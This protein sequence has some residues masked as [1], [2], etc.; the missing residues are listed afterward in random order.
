MLKNQYQ[1]LLE[2]FKGKKPLIN[3]V[4][5]GY[6]LG[7]PD[8][9][10]AIHLANKPFLDYLFGKYPMT[11]LA[12]HG[13]HVGLPG[14]NDLGGSEVGHLT[15]GAGQVIFQGPTLI[16]N[17]IK[18]GSFF[19]SPVLR[20]LLDKAAGHA[21]HLIGLLSDGNVHSHIDHFEA[22]ILEAER[23]KIKRLYLHALLDG[24]D[25]GIQT[26]QD[27]I[28]RIQSLFE[29]VEKDN[30]GFEYRIASGGGREVI[31]MDRDQNWK[32]VQR[33]WETHVLGKSGQV[34]ENAIL[35]LEHFR[36]RTPG[37]IDQDCPPF[38]VKNK[39]GEIPVIRD[40][41]QVL[42]M[43]FRGDRA[44]QISR[45]FVEE[46]FLPFDIKTKPKVGFA[47]IMVYD[48]DTDLPPKRIISSP[49]V[50]NPFGKRLVELGLKQFRLAE[51]QKYAHVTF[52]Y[53]GGYRNP[54]DPE[55]ETY[56]LI[57]SDKIDS[58]AFQPKMKAE[59]IALQAQKAILSQKYDFGLINFAN[60][61]MV[62]HTGDLKATIRAVETVDH[63]VQA[64]CQATL[65]AGGIAVITADHGNADEMLILNPKTK[66]EEISTKH[67]ISPVPFIIYDPAH[68]D[69]YRLKES[70]PSNPLN[71]SMIAATNFILMGLKVP[72]DLNDPLFLL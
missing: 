27:Y 63:A 50:K 59:E 70:D 5:D 19:R 33:G 1:S 23:K 30:P 42:F 67:S 20:E 22:V 8:H 54:L 15:M 29:R 44:A 49:E 38:N 37:L 52:F 35:A 4:L 13:F 21:L 41:D 7:K 40:L 57:N 43:N 32:K 72:D 71:L 68:Q 58:F 26:A 11:E 62:G 48:E 56:Y 2:H 6:G 61:D 36:A 24:R 18:D 51:T 34:F 64:I 47:G 60:A 53:N 25:V 55:K 16:T 9:T 69:L 17:A 28:L 3:I 45:V 66:K 12:T 39:N 65:K 14:K 10:N 31:T 46:S